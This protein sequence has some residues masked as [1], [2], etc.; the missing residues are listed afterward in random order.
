VPIEYA[1][2]KIFEEEIRNLKGKDYDCVIGF[3]GGRDSAYLLWYI[4]N[5]LNLR[6]VAYSMDNGLVPDQTK[7]NIYRIAEILNIRLILEK[8]PYLVKCLKHHLRSWIKKPSAAMIGMFCIG[9]RLG[10]DL[11]LYNF[12]VKEK[13][14]AIILGGTP[15][16]GRGYKRN[17]MKKNNSFIKGYLNQV[18]NNPYWLLNPYCVATQLREYWI[19]YRMVLHKRNIKYFGPF[20]K[21]IKW[22]ETELVSVI[23]NE[24]DWKKNPNIKSTWRG[25]CDVAILKAYLYRKTLGFNDIDDGLSTL[26]RDKQI[27]RA[28]ALK[29]LR[30]EGSCSEEILKEIVENIGVNYRDF[31]N[32]VEGI[33]VKI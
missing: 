27:S 2:G 26:I 21:Y 16:E 32:A 1:G 13:I 6:V 25:D 14:P 3:S 29:R 10:I 7:E 19:H 12:A 9:C 4:A 8:K 17:I 5:K 20:W 33:E 18:K 31:K 28:E 30:N 11:G 24:L 23:E 22:D 15:F